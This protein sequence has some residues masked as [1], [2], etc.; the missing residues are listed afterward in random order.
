MWPSRHRY[1]K[2]THQPYSPEAAPASTAQASATCQSSASAQATSQ[3]VHQGPTAKPSA[4]KGA[5]Q[6]RVDVDATPGGTPTR[7]PKKPRPVNRHSPGQQDKVLD[8]VRRLINEERAYRDRGAAGLDDDHL[9]LIRG[10]RR[11]GESNYA[12]AVCNM[13]LLLGPRRRSL[14]WT[15]KRWRFDYRHG[16]VAKVPTL[17]TLKSWSRR[18]EWQARAYLFDH[19]SLDEVL[20]RNELAEEIRQDARQELDRRRLVRKMRKRGLLP[21]ETGGAATRKKT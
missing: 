1:S 6:T 19:I 3:A 16:L 12:I 11:P 15:L 9:L 8:Q 18:Y 14:A 13:Y 2:Q 20:R 10:V 5:A 7:S 17:D 4:Q 21:P